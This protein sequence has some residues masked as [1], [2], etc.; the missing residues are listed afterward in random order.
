MTKFQK[1]YEERRI[2]AL[3]M[4]KDGSTH[5]VI[6][7]SDGISRLG[8]TKMLN[9]M[10]EYHEF[11]AMRAK[12]QAKREAYEAKLEVLLA[13]FYADERAG[14]A[15]FKNVEK[16]ETCWQWTGYTVSAAGYGGLQYHYFEEVYGERLY[17]H[18]I[19]WC[20][21]HGKPVPEG[22][23]ILHKCH[24]KLCVNPDHLYVGTHDDNMADMVLRSSY[25]YNRG[26]KDYLK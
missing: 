23:Q 12:M 9:S 26:V 8:I 10:P 13:P 7:K 1:E 22:M 5:R 3:N 19:S 24:N 2:A 20:I 15:F 25:D 11:R 6:A 17:A 4:Y 14:K 21:H 16:T 18:R